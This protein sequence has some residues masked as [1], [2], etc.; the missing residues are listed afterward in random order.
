MAKKNS[1]FA[2]KAISRRYYFEMV[3]QLKKTYAF[4]RA[5][6]L[7]KNYNIKKSFRKMKIKCTI[8]G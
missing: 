7:K 1:D 8:F 4:K 3:C 5:M 2:S 6:N